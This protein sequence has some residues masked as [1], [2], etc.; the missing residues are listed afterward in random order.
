[1]VYM[2]VFGIT[3]QEKIASAMYKILPSDLKKTIRSFWGG[4]G[5]N[6]RIIDN[7]YL[8]YLS[9]MREGVKPP[10]YTDNQGGNSAVLITPRIAQSTNVNTQI[11]D[12]F[13]KS[14][15]NLSKNGTIEFSKYDPV[16]VE[17]EKKIQST[18]TTEK[19]IFSKTLEAV[20][21]GTNK[22]IILSI[23]G[24]TGYILFTSK[25]RVKND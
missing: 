10:E 20:D 9:I 19:N 2:G 12:S 16:K 11:V 17:R 5:F 18:F 25:K 23:I 24:L 15:Y 8:S 6:T 21:K 4:S 1:M 7:L 3:W 13:L 14:L 22:I